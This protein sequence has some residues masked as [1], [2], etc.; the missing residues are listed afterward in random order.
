MPLPLL[1][2]RAISDSC[3][4]WSLS[5]RG[6]RGPIV[7]LS[8]SRRERPIC[9]IASTQRVEQ[10][11]AWLHGDDASLAVDSQGFTGTNSVV[12][13]RQ[14]R[15]LATCLAPSHRM[16]GSA[17]RSFHPRL[18]NIL[19]MPMPFLRRPCRFRKQSK[20]NQALD[21]GGGLKEIAHLLYL[22][23]ARLVGIGVSNGHH[24][25]SNPNSRAVRWHLGPEGP[26]R[27]WSN[28]GQRSQLP[29]SFQAASLLSL[30]LGCG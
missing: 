10:R 2:H 9:D 25:M 8:Q 28:L 14:R 15:C 13:G 21:H 29:K 5:G 7:A 3:L 6:G 11:R 17:S 26:R 27:C 1:A 16:A 30:G 18:C 24:L 19:P 22:A 4:E 23:S 12:P 20:L